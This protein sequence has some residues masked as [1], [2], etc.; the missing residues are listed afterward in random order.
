MRFRKL[1]SKEISHL[2]SNG[3]RSETWDTIE[4]VDDFEPANIRNVHFAGT[5]RLGRFS[6]T[7]DL[8]PGIVRTCGL[9]DTSVTDCS[10]GNNVYIAGVHHILGY[11]IGD[12]VVIENTGTVA[13]T[14]PTAFG[15]GVRINVLNEA[16][17]RELI[18]FDILS[19]QIAYLMV[20]CRHEPA[21]IERLTNLIEVYVKTKAASTGKIESGVRIRDCVSIRNI[22]VGPHARLTGAT[23][24]ENGTI[25]SNPSDPV[26]IGQNVSAKNFIIQSGTIIDTGALLTDCFIGQGVRI[27][28]QLSA[29]HS[30]FFANCEGFHGEMCS[31]FAGP[32]SVSHHKST[33]LIAGMF[34]FYNAGS[35]SNQSNHMYKLGPV[36]QGILERGAKTGSFSYLLWPSRIGP[37]T[38]VIGAHHANFDASEFPFSYIHEEDGKSVLTPALNLFSVGTHRDSIKWPDRDRRKD[39]LKHDL[40]HFD[41]FNP[42]TIGKVLKA[43]K[44]LIKLG[45]TAS[46]DQEFVSYNGLSIKRLLIKTV[47]KY[48]ELAVQMYI[49]NELLKRLENAG[50]VRS[51]QDIRRNLMYEVT[52]YCPSWI[53]CGGMFVPKSAYDTLLSS[54]GNGRLDS[55][56]AVRGRLEEI[57]AGYDRATW[58]WCA[59]LI[60]RRLELP[61]NQIQSSHLIRI[62]QQWHDSSLK[63][64]NMIGND[65]VKEFDAGSRIGFGV[66]GDET[67][68]D[69]DFDA[70]RGT[71]DQ[72]PFILRLKKQSE[73]IRS[74]KD[75][76]IRS[77]EAL[78]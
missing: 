17:G 36:H 48:Y 11:Q 67:V 35:G 25:G 69:L 76:V 26:T 44:I 68:R 55:L 66:D 3:C 18:I 47:V 15:N 19:S 45:S 21:F 74:R 12:N 6:G 64:N 50:P 5:I 38:A 75:E 78:G 70:V 24:L 22:A 1:Q 49:G 4:V 27:G 39:P 10:V 37:F 8:E 59:T 63:L 56:E 43:Q 65:A 40:L 58:A 16:G 62:V 61:I 57:F 73:T 60:E 14:G 77:L 54:V 31:V 23:L 2:Q 42:Y 33:L 29:E 53:D 20:T 28:K 34:S 41:L 72:H 13:V 71:Y 30:A 7:I 52:D 32:Y 51:I 9:Y 46:K